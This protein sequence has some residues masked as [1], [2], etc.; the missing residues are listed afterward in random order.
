MENSW[1]EDKDSSGKNLRLSEQSF[2]RYIILIYQRW[3][4][5]NIDRTLIHI[6][7]LPSGLYRGQL[8]RLMIGGLIEQWFFGFWLSSQEPNRE[9]HELFWSLSREWDPPDRTWDKTAKNILVVSHLWRFFWSTKVTRF[10]VKMVPLAM[11]RMVWGE[12]SLL[13]KVNELYHEAGCND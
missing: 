13:D 11:D 8:S 4:Y 9:K 2:R 12:L 1:I 10:K 3:S 5:Q 7:I 6:H